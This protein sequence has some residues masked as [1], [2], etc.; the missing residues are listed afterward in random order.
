MTPTTPNPDPAFV[1]QFLVAIQFFLGIGV[2]VVALINRKQKREVTL[3]PEVVT[4]AELGLVT[5]PIEKRVGGL[6]RE[7]SAIRAE[8]KADR[9]ALM[10]DA[11]RGRAEIKAHISQTV[12][13][14][15]ER[16]D[17]ILESLAHKKEK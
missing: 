8:M 10:E 1:W 13:K 2:S 17:R 3:S 5:Q 16:V 4:K 6:E 9:I 11:G 12:T 14:V 7:V 15:H